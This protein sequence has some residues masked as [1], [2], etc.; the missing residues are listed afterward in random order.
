MKSLKK[1]QIITLIITVVILAAV[2]TGIFVLRGERSAGEGPTENGLTENGPKEDGTARVPDKSPTGEAAVAPAGEK[3]G[4]EKGG[5]EK[6]GEGKGEE[7][8]GGEEKG[9]EGKGGE[10]NGGEEKG[11]EGKGGEG[12]GEEERAEENK[13]EGGS[14]EEG[15]GTVPVNDGFVLLEGGSFAM[16]SPDSERQRGADEISHEVTVSAF[17]AD[18]FEVTQKDYEAVM[19]EN[20]SFFS[21]DD[22]PVENVTWYDAVEY[23][24]RLSEIRGLTP[25]YRVDA[26]TVSW[27]RAADGYRLLTEAEWEYAAR[28]GTETIYSFGNQVHSDFANFEGSYPYLIEENYVSRRDPEVV[29]SRNRGTTIGVDEL[30]PNAFGLYH[31]HGNVA[32]WCFDY[33]GE[34]DLD[35]SVDPAGAAS[36]SLRVNRG[37]SYNDFGKH[38]RSAYRSAT[39]PMDADQ[40]LGFRICRSGEEKEETVATT[41]SLDITIPE[42]PKIL[43]AYF[44]YSGNTENAAEIIREKT[45]AD[46]FEITMENPYNGN[47]Y[48]V[49]QYDLMND[50]HPGLAAHVEDMSRYDVILLG[51]PTWWATMPM[52]VYSFLEEYDFS[53]KTIL[54]FSS[55][56]GTMFGD[57]VSDLSKMVPGAYVG[58]G[59]EFHYSG[60]SGL[61]DEISRWLAAS[62]LG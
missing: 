44:S 14:G 25:A 21:G 57:S 38:L 51:Y 60:G 13:S 20:P 58:I 55:H 59:F 16:G 8:K 47:I 5:E 31:M 6:G 2:G 41:Y 33:Y 4:E 3:D 23:C 43:I 15:A 22:L 12:N 35:D 9:E 45:G 39:N 1:A 18:P 26:G 37:G 56:G 42:D 29:T 10:G 53:G 49:S 36:G 48:E 46:L 7:E 62:G 28:G 50:I 34:Y 11:E 61:S 54:S 30:P 40:N 24:N 17:Y 27:N 52:P 32:E 19:G